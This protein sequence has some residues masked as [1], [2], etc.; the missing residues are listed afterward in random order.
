MT[1]TDPDV[2]HPPP[3]RLVLCAGLGCAA[4]G[5]LLAVALGALWLARQPE[6]QAPSEHLE[7]VFGA[8]G[9]LVDAE[10]TVDVLRRRLRGEGV[11]AEVQRDGETFVVTLSNPSNGNWAKAFLPLSTSVRVMIAVDR[12]EPSAL[13]AAADE[14]ARAAQGPVPERQFTSAP[15]KP[16]ASGAEERPLIL[17]TEGM[18]G[19]EDFA[20]F[21]RAQD[22]LGL[23][24]LGFTL[25]PTGAQ[26]LRRLTR[27]NRDKR[28]AIVIDGV[29]ISAPTIRGAI[30]KKGIVEGGTQG[31]KPGELQELVGKLK[32]G[33]LPQPLV[34]LEERLERP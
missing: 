27:D 29:V 5:L 31:W 3:S 20:D 6:P 23:P 26:K 32:A 18:L 34:L 19:S 15:W 14:E 33:E 4:F 13:K 17:R 28:L 30:G 22:A 11:G 25:T 21:Y 12:D 1:S 8:E 9:E 24:C 16:T 2:P 7:L 10:R